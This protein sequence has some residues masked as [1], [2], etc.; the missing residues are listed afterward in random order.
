MQW[1]PHGAHAA[2]RCQIGQPVALGTSSGG[3][4]AALRICAGARLVS[5]TWSADAAVAQRNLQRQLTDVGTVLAKLEWLL[6][7]PRRLNGRETARGV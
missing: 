3:R 5:E 1:A 4:T 7:D 2:R 6:A